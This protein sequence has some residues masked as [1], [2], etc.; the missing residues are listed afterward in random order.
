MWVWVT[1]HGSFPLAAVVVR[2]GSVGR[3]LDGDDPKHELRVLRFTVIGTVLGGLLN[4]VGPSCF[5]SPRTPAPSD[6]FAA[7]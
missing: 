1:A 6:V 2:R 4:P 3:R 5:V 7:P